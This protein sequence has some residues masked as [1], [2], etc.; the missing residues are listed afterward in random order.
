V[1]LPAGVRVVEQ[2]DE[3]AA[4]FG[5]AP[6]VHV[7]G[8]ADLAPAYWDASTWY[9]RGDAVVGVVVFPGGVGTAIYALTAHDEPGTVDLFADLVHE[10]P[11][12]GLCIT[13]TGCMAVAA[14]AR[15]IEPYGAHVR[16]VL[17]DWSAVGQPVPPVEPLTSA[18]EAEALRLYE[19]EPGAAYFQP[20]ML[21]DESFVGLRLEGQ[22]VAAAGT[23]VLSEEFGVASIGAVYVHPEH[24]G[25]GFGAAVTA[26]VIH[27]LQGR[28]EVIGLNVKADNNPALAIYRRLGFSQLMEFEE[29]DLL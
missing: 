8:L 19:T 3:L 7:Y 26:G 4:L 9:R 10:F 16:Y 23:H 15:P 12:G 29:F 13:A 6:P 21:G 27:R 18:D 20:F 1:T 25:H 5:E 22:L 17:T 2:P 14:A 28:A 24:R 11:S